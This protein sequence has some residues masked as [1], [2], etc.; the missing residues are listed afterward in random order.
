MNDYFIQKDTQK[1]III[2]CLKKIIRVDF[3]V[4]AFPKSK[5][6]LPN[7]EFNEFFCGKRLIH[8]EKKCK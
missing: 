4:R 7:L 8:S 1:M 2:G 6:E 3:S 5:S